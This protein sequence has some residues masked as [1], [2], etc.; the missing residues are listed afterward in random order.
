M[1]LYVCTAYSLFAAEHIQK[2]DHLWNAVCIFYKCGCIVG[3]ADTGFS[4]IWNDHSGICT[5]DILSNPDRNYYRMDQ[6][7]L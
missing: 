4:G 5:D 7:D 6:E 1:E 3:F 2:S